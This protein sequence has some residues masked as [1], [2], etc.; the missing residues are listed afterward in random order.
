MSEL[1][2]NESEPKPDPRLEQLSEEELI[3]HYLHPIYPEAASRELTRRL[4][5]RGMTWHS[6]Q[7]EEGEGV[8]I[9]PKGKRP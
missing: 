2:G 5:A 9:Y 6:W 7:G 4:G 8:Q 3:E 1:L